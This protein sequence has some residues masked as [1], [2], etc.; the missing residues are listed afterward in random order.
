MPGWTLRTGA[1]VH[2]TRFPINWKHLLGSLTGAFPP[3]WLF[4]AHGGVF[5][6]PRCPKYWFATLDSWKVGGFNKTPKLT[7]PNS[8]PVDFAHSMLSAQDKSQCVMAKCKQMRCC[9][10][11]RWWNSFPADMRTFLKLTTKCNISGRRHKFQYSKDVNKVCSNPF[12]ASNLVVEGVNDHK[13]Q[14]KIKR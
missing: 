12:W 11:P 6:T 8:H 13:R 4:R 5:R 14:S 7:V 1:I 10:Q 2:S 9:S 3:N